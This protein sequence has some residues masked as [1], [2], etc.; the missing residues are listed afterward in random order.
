MSEA[1]QNKRSYLRQVQQE[2]AQKKRDLMEQQKEDMKSL[3]Q[4]YSSE[5]KKVDE[6]SAAVVNHIKS[7]SPDAK[8][9]R[10][11]RIEKAAEQREAR[12]QEV[13]QARSDRASTRSPASRADENGGEVE[14]SSVEKKSL[15]NRK[16]MKT[17]A[18]TTQQNYE[19][20]ETDDFYRVQNRGSRVSENS[21]GFVI[22]AYAPEHEKDNLRVSI[23]RNKAVV[24][25]QRKFGDE[26]VEGNKS[27]RTN[28]FQTFREEFKLSRPVTSEGMTRERVGDFVRFT[29]PKLEA[30]DG[31]E[32]A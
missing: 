9:E 14:E 27:M 19:T 3:R 10:L 29:I 8:Q 6:D 15:Y 7:N 21:Q 24:S 1:I 17:E 13:E 11:D 20:K 5:S 31:E 4:Y 26:A 28:N 18:K 30:L 2:Q 25:G 32:N 22:E 16:A 23:H 12:Q